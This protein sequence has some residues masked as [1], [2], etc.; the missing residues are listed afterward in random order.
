VGCSDEAHGGRRRDGERRACRQRNICV[1]A[2]AVALASGCAS[3]PKDY[4]CNE[5][6]VARPA[7]SLPPGECRKFPVNAKEP[8]NPSGVLVSQGATYRMSIGPSD[9]PWIDWFVPA[10]PEGGWSGLAS[11]LAWLGRV[12][13]RTHAANLSTLVCTVGQNEREARPVAGNPLFEAKADDEL[14][15]F[16]NDWPGGWA[17]ENN[18]GCVQVKICDTRR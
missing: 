12:H 8:W 17:Y 4:V 5:P 3:A 2:F 14:F 7:T 16:A 10:T 18:Q 9:P 13:A 11:P 15:C 6:Q 1:A